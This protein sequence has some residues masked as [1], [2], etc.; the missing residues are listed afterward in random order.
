MEREPYGQPILQNAKVAKQQRLAQNDRNY[1][2][3]HGIT[4]VAIEAGDDQM[5]CRKNRSRRAQALQSEADK[6]IQQPWK[7]DE[8]QKHPYNPK[9]VEVEERS[10][11]PPV[12]EPPGHK[13]C[14]GSG[15]NDQK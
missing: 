11:H 4:H 6:R 14:N 9:R 5:A 7:A 15:R 10:L 3:V 1:G 8:N 12:R 2:N 13:A